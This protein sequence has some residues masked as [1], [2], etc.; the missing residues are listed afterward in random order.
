V[1]KYLKQMGHQLL[2]LIPSL[3]TNRSQ[4]YKGSWN[5]WS[6]S[7]LSFEL[8]IAIGGMVRSFSWLEKPTRVVSI[9]MLQWL[10]GARTT[11][12]YLIIC[13]YWSYAQIIFLARKADQGGLNTN[14]IMARWS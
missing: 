9:R 5:R 3:R 2:R 10:D 6:P 4:A 12:E 13:I 7:W 8:F 1:R 14:A 11:L